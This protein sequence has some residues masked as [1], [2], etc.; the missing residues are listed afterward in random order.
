MKV[1]PVV[2]Q[3]FDWKNGGLHSK[4][5]EVQQQSNEAAEALVQYIKETLEN[6]GLLR[7]CI[8][9]AS[10][11]CNTMFGGLRRDAEGKNVF[12]KLINLLD[13]KALIGVGCA[14][15]TG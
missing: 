15:H 14:A 7:K 12:A 11:N 13:N 1:F 3:Y 5:I 6:H 4:L 9:F 10:D 8:A 2:I